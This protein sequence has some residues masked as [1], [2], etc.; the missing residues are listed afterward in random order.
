MRGVYDTLTI[1]AAF[2]ASPETVDVLAE[3]DIGELFRRI[4]KVTGA[5]QTQIG[6][7]TGLSQAQVSEIM[8]GRRQVNTIDVLDRIMDGLAIPG[9]ARM[10][11][12]CGDRTYQIAPQQDRP[13]G[14]DASAAGEFSDVVAVYPTRS[15]FTSRMPPHVL[16]DGARDIRAAGLSL[17]LIYQQYSDSR[18]L[19][20]IEG[21]AKLRCL[22]LDPDGEAIR[23]REREEGYPDGY[24]SS[25]TR[26]NIR[27]LLHR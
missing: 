14:P 25:L 26:M 17:N 5:S 21:G 19:H 4:Q 9:A 11:L 12:L 7:A 3:R 24:L 23:A 13:S 20:L 22:F 27:N 18:L 16:F 6:I 10:A 8:G 2:W 1:P 15:E